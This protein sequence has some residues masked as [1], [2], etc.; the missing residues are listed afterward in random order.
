MNISAIDFPADESELTPAQVHSAASMRIAV[1]RLAEA[2][3]SL[4]CRLHQTVLLGANTLVLGEVVMFHVDD[5]LVGP[6]FH[7]NGFAPIGRMGSPSTYCKTTDRF[8][9]PRI[10]YATW[11]LG[12]SVTQD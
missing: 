2:K 12:A 9:L 11:S 7:I 6:R 4:E 5:A 10:S 3:A 1:P 8:E